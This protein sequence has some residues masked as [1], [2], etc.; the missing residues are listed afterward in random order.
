MDENLITNAGRQPRQPN[1]NTDAVMSAL[2][3]RLTQQG[4]GIS[5]S[6]SS[7]LA[8]TISAAM[9]DIQTAGDLTSQRLQ[10][11]R[12]RE[13]AFA[14]DRQGAQITGALESR[15]GFGTQVAALRE[16]T[17]TTDKSVRDLDQR[18]Q[19]AILS[20]DANTASQIAGLR[21]EKLKF[22]V[23]QEQNFYRN[24]FSLA[25]LSM[26]QEGMEREDERFFA[27]QEFEERMFEQRVFQDERNMMLGLAAEFGVEVGDGDNIETMIGKISPFVDERRGLELQEI[28]LRMEESR[29]RI[30]E[31]RAGAASNNALDPSTVEALAMSFINGD[32][33]F[34]A[35]LKGNQAGQ[36]YAAAMNLRNQADKGLKSI[37]DNAT[38]PNDFRNKVMN[39]PNIM[40]TEE[41]VQA[42]EAMYTEQ[43]TKAAREQRKTEK[44]EKRSTN[45]KNWQDTFR[46]PLFNPN[47][48]T[49]S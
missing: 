26:Q 14:R 13:V 16:L 15:T 9:G 8:N 37:A 32:V 34:L 3:E 31:A 30:A 27:G 28:R 20:N 10:S 22:A 12:Q 42:Y 49:T 2:T 36:V 43:W 41:Q 25:G 33:G 47:N 40:A 44:K 7:E 4:Q 46:A 23:E 48:I 39:N 11:E 21:L 1:P 45:I 35:G 29:A 18:Y 5:S 38:S 19:E 6:A 17:E 24:L